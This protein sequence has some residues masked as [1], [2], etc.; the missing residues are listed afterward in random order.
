MKTKIYSAPCA[1]VRKTSI[2][3]SIL[4]GSNKSGGA[5][6]TGNDI[7]W[8]NGARKRSTV[9]VDASRD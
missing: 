1:E 8:D 4:A 7:P 3:A 2:R 9:S 5:G 6:V